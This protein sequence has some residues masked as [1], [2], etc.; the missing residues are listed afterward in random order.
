MHIER[1]VLVS[2]IGETTSCPDGLLG[3]RQFEFCSL[4][5]RNIGEGKKLNT[6]F[7]SEVER[8]LGNV[9]EGSRKRE[10]PEHL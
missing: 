8:V 9:I 1:R 5:F 6:V 3:G 7:R 2:R 4:A 10:G